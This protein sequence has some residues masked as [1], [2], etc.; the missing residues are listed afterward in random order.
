MGE[1]VIRIGQVLMLVLALPA[2]RLAADA[3]YFQAASIFAPGIALPPFPQAAG[4]GDAYTAVAEGTTALA[5]N[6]AGLDMMSDHQLAFMHNEWNS[7]LGIRQEYLAYSQKLGPGGIGAA[8]NY[9]NLGELETRD[10]DG[11]LTGNLMASDFSISLGY[12][13]SFLTPGLHLGLMPELGFE[14]AGTSST[15]LVGLSGGALY[16]WRDLTL[17]AALMHLGFGPDNSELASA[18]RAG[19]AYRFPA[20]C[21]LLAADASVPFAS[22]SSVSAGLEWTLAKILTIRAGWRQ[23]L[24]SELQDALS[25]P[26]AGLGF[27]VNM[28]QFDYAFVSLGPFPAA[29]RLSAT[30]EFGDDLFRPTVVIKAEDTTA[31]AKAFREQGEEFLKSNQKVEALVAFKQAL[32][33]VPGD[34]ESAQ[35]AQQIEAELKS[36]YVKG[37]KDSVVMEMIEKKMKS[38][39]KLFKEGDYK[40]AVVEWEAVLELD[41]DSDEAYTKIR[42]AKALFN[43]K[44]AAI[45]A[46][47]DAALKD[48]DLSTAVRKYRA[49]LVLEPSFALAKTRL[50]EI[51]SRITDEI[52]RLYRDG[53]DYYLKGDYAQALKI[54][55][56]GLGLDTRDPFNLE[57][58]IARAQANLEFT[59][60]KEQ[61]APLGP[62][63]K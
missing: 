6:P 58:D 63:G 48:N 54:W 46:A 44:L 38:G 12:G 53:I 2:A 1:P 25:G 23:Q 50:T 32:Q 7:S 16:T 4:M 55:E 31:T 52:K 36:G 17:G 28:F 8:L 9:F 51:Q 30:L 60:S 49:A 45:V 10:Q 57:R 37:P 34:E 3:E 35:K 40:K 15:T 59:N 24:S 20:P 56:Q 33:A 21:L 61:E 47:G 19:L 41:P 13:A 39:N 18:F 27:K 11:N 62:G 22:A 26:A 14:S 42:Q 29:Q 5:W 43:S